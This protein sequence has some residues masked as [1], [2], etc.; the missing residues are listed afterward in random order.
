MPGYDRRNRRT[1]ACPPPR[2]DEDWRRLSLLLGS[3]FA[4]KSNARPSLTTI[5]GFVSLQRIGPD[6]TDRRSPKRSGPCSRSTGAT[7]A[8]T[9]YRRDEDG[10]PHNQELIRPLCSPTSPAPEPAIGTDV[11]ILP[12]ARMRPAARFGGATG[13]CPDL[14]V[15]CVMSVMEDRLGDARILA[16]A[17]S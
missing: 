14:C 8:L 13:R 11:P 5:L 16:S 17:A 4:R 15:R 7:G 2:T 6:Q 3:G 9:C 12:R 1:V 10:G